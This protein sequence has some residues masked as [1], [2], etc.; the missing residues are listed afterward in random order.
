[1]AESGPRI[2]HEIEQMGAALRDLSPALASFADR[3]VED[4]FSRPEAIR[5][6]QT[7]L[8]ELV[9]PRKIT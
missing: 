9:Q 6:T 7:L 8:A 1:M 5:L 2:Q 3:L 4:G